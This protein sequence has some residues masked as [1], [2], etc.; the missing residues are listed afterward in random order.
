M[1]EQSSLES[2]LYKNPFSRIYFVYPVSAVGICVHNFVSSVTL[3][4]LCLSFTY[5]P[6]LWYSWSSKVPVEG[7][8]NDFIQVISCSITSRDTCLETEL[9]CRATESPPSIQHHDFCFL[10]SYV[11]SCFR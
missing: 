10:L 5:L 6:L 11:V 2:G 3:Q 9:S 8:R 1:K 4:Y 7:C